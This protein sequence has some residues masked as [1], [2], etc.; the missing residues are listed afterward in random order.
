MS[1]LETSIIFSLVMLVLSGL[2]IGPAKLCAETITDDREAME[3]I[4][5]GNSEI[6]SPER[7]NTFFTGISDNYRIIYGAV[8]GE[9]ADEEE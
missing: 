9:V 2:I 3:D 5:D 1:T 7:L 4:L 8:V 6:M